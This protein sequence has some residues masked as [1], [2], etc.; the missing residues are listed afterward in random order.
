MTPFQSTGTLPGRIRVAG[1]SRNGYGRNVRSI[2]LPYLL[3]AVLFSACA[4]LPQ[5]PR[6]APHANLEVQVTYHQGRDCLLAQRLTLNDGKLGLG[7]PARV[8]GQPLRG[9]LRV[10]TGQAR[11]AFHTE[12]SHADTVRRRVTTPIYTT[13]PP[14]QA[15][16]LARFEERDAWVTEFVSDGL[17]DARVETQLE[18]GASYVMQIDFRGSGD[19]SMQIVRQPTQ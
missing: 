17:C 4:T 16:I 18:V 6:E 1:V 19:C 5:P 3:A 10:D 9:Q 15:A 11:F 14:G 2:G 7:Y 12:L 13:V 8:P